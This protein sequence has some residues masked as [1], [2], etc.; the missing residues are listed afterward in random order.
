MQ[1]P[2]PDVSIEKQFQSRNASMSFS[3]M[4]GDSMSPTMPIVSFMEP[5]QA[6][7]PASG[8]GVR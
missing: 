3:S 4:T 5:I 6:S 7:C 2:K 1:S 8:D